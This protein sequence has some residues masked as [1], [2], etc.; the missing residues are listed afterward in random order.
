MASPD[1]F[2]AAAEYIVAEGK[3]TQCF[4]LG[5]QRLR[6]TVTAITPTN[7]SPFAQESHAA[8]VV[9]P[10]HSVGHRTMFSHARLPP[11]LTGRTG[12]HESHIDPQRG[13]GDDP[14]QAISPQKMSELVQLPVGLPNRYKA[15]TFKRWSGTR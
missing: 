14:K 15:D 2:I 10:S 5:E 9:D 12:S 1:E 13:I 7:R 3:L 11:S 4:V 8:P 6:W